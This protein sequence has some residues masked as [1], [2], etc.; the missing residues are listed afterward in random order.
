L[1]NNC[2]QENILENYKETKPVANRLQNDLNEKKHSQENF[3]ENDQPLNNILENEKIKFQATFLGN[4]QETMPLANILENV[5]NENTHHHK[6]TLENVQE[7]KPFSN[8]LENVVKEN[9]DDDLKEVINNDLRCQTIS[10]ASDLSQINYDDLLPE[11]D[12]INKKDLIKDEKNLNENLDD[13]EK[14][15]L[16]ILFSENFNEEEYKDKYPNSA[17]QNAFEF[18]TS[19]KLPDILIKKWEELKFSKSKIKK[20][21]EKQKAKIRHKYSIDEK[22]QLKINLK[23]DC[24]V[25]PHVNEIKQI[26]MK[27][28]SCCKG[29]HLG[30]NRTIEKIKEEKYYWKGIASYT[31]KYIDNCTVCILSI[32]VS[33]KKA[34]K[35]MVFDKPLDRVIIDLCFLVEELSI[36]SDKLKESFLYL[37]VGVDHFSKFIFA[38]LLI[39]REAQTIEIVLKEFLNL[40]GK[41]KQLGTDHGRE[42]ENNLLKDFCISHS[43][44]H[45]MG[46][47]RHPQS[48]GAVERGIRT[49]HSNLQKA[50]IETENKEE[51]DCENSLMDI[52]SA[53]NNT[54][55]TTTKYKPKFIFYTFLAQ[56]SN[57]DHEKNSELYKE[58]KSNIINRYKTNK[59]RA[60]L[61]V[62]GKVFLISKMTYLFAK[63]VIFN[64]VEKKKNI[65]VKPI[66]LKIKVK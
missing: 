7:T 55:H 11:N 44:E 26:I 37:F 65:L 32:S 5:L 20:K 53:Y 36:P 23:K 13:Q 17:A 21:K 35:V 25:V 39:N 8:L 63:V 24:F 41:P 19:K 33:K 47:V 40:Y 2:P 52:I 58:I 56:S 50:Y 38:K 31:K 27:N 1:I 28:H 45:V 48:Q 3:L 51:F 66:R 29:S 6:N 14:K 9:N 60:S 64:K 59:E 54:K 34:S 30:L 61:E 49:I 10:S 43:I 57:N 16:E 46:K 62:G 42:F 22:D 12:N 15:I 4:D 18:L